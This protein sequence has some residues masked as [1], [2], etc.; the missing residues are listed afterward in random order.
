MALLLA[1]WAA[2]TIAQERSPVYVGGPHIFPTFDRPA[3][4]FVGL[5]RGAVPLGIY[6][7]QP[8]S[9]DV[10]IAIAVTNRFAVIAQ[11]YSA[12]AP[13]NP[14]HRSWYDHSFTEVGIGRL[15][16]MTAGR[17]RLRDQLTLGTGASDL[18]IR[19]FDGE[20]PPRYR[21]DGRYYRLSY[22]TSAIL[23]REYAEV[24]V[25]GRASAV[26]FTR[27]ERRSRDFSV[28]PPPDPYTQAMDSPGSMTAV[29]LEPGLMARIG[30]RYFKVGPD[31]SFSAPL[32]GIG[33]AFGAQRVIF[34]LSASINFQPSGTR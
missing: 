12:H 25:A 15:S 7:G 28:A 18:A 31:I 3:D 20:D 33:T 22:Q 17:W 27:L 11:S 14:S 9:R 1:L 5:A 30:F 29:Y 4:A 6:S 34:G 23:R 24:G 10:Q 32:P 16:R 19:S 8:I 13:F 21:A 26:H 2:P